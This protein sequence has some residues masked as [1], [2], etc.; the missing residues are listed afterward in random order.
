MTYAETFRTGAAVLALFLLSCAEPGPAAEAASP[1]AV[2][3]DPQQS[4]LTGAPATAE[5][6]LTGSETVA[7]A[8]PALRAG[9]RVD[10]ELRGPG[11]RTEN[12]PLDPRQPWLAGPLVESLDDGTWDYTVVV[13]PEV[14]FAP[15]IPAPEVGVDPGAG[16]D[17]RSRI[18]QGAFRAAAVA[19]E[20]LDANG[21][22]VAAGQAAPAQ[23]SGRFEG[24]FEVLGGRAWPA[25]S[26]PGLEEGSR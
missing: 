23:D 24:T 13:T 17:L 26:R 22:N 18:E 15:D 21:R 6:R 12:L 5:Q 3:D 19:P 11:G 2:E 10:V 1:R 25:G 4:A 14:A 8:L 9:S 16:L 20:V 7:L